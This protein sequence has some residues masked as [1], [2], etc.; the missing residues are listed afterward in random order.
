V[1]VHGINI[2]VVVAAPPAAQTIT[3]AQLKKLPGA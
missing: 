3:L 2:P 1:D